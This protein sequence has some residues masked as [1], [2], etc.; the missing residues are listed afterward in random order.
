MLWLL[1]QVQVCLSLV[2]LSNICSQCC[3]WIS[4][5]ELAGIIGSFFLCALFLCKF[6][7]IS[8]SI[9]GNLIC[10][11]FSIAVLAF[12]VFVLKSITAKKNGPK[13]HFFGLLVST[14]Q[15]QRPYKSH[16]KTS[17][18]RTKQ[19]F[20]LQSQPARVAVHLPSNV[21]STG[22]QGVRLEGDQEFAHQEM[23]I[24]FR[25][26]RTSVEEVAWHEYSGYEDKK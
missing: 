14:R 18:Q 25:S 26:F 6:R 17:L 16:K 2:N 21:I 23:V 8:S 20:H 1:A 12:S 9:P 5:Q 4:L 11:D 15:S 3:Y 10:F 13:G 22:L 19:P 7:L 24:F